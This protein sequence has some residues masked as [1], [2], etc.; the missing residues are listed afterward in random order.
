MNPDINFEN[1]LTYVNYLNCNKRETI[2]GYKY[3]SHIES[4]VTNV[5]YNIT[6]SLTP[7]TPIQ[8]EIET[9]RNLYISCFVTFD[10]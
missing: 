5:A 8:A 7:V 1:Q 2:G 9:Y 4:F 6:P 10:T 3:S